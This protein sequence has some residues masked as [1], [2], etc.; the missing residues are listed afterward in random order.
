MAELIISQTQGTNFTPPQLEQATVVLPATQLSLF[1][2]Q[3]HRLPVKVTHVLKLLHSWLQTV[4][5][6]LKSLIGL[7]IP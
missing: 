1:T 5:N 4:L 7:T 2:Q 6:F 3:V